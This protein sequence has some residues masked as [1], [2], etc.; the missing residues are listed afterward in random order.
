M[1]GV[2]ISNGIVALRSRYLLSGHSLAFKAFAGFMGT[3]GSAVNA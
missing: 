2:G 3:A 1:L